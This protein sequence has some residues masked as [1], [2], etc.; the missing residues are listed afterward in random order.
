VGGRVVDCPRRW[1][2]GRTQSGD[3]LVMPDHL[4]TFTFNPICEFAPRGFAE[5]GWLVRR[6]DDADPA[7][8]MALRPPTP[9]AL[10]FRTSVT[11]LELLSC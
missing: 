10:M 6:N 4:P 1:D 11:P 8:V 5:S 2:G 9:L 7:P 3:K